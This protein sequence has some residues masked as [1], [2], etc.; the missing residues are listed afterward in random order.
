MLSTVMD[1]SRGPAPNIR[2]RS[3]AES[4]AL[5]LRIKSAISEGRFLPG[6]RLPTERA[7]SAE[8]GVA[9]NTVR[10]TMARLMREGL[11]LREVG[12][13]TFVA[14]KPEAQPAAGEFSL[15]EL[16]E[17][18]LLFEPALVDL[19]I[20]RATETDFATFDAALAAME[21]ADNW[22]AYKEAK[23]ALHLA[24]ARASRNRFIIHMVETILTSRRAAGWG[25]P[26]GHHTPLAMVRQTA[27]R[28]NAAI[29][30]ALRARDAATARDLMRDY[31][32]RT[33]AS[34]SAA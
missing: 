10:K 30:A 27:C 33:L 28:D 18:R 31:L 17:A 15:P 24:I 7:L 23:Y 21:Q 20:E 6:T 25:R 14:E 2:A 4:R 11:I 19:V 1:E 16:F 5:Y 29:V 34:V 32:V 12:R 26:G 3:E 22:A 8:Y 13:G 9:R